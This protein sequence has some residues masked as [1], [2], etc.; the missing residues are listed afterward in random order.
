MFLKINGKLALLNNKLVVADGNGSC[1]CANCEERPCDNDNPCGAPG[2]GCQC[3]PNMGDPHPNCPQ[4]NPNG[5]GWCRHN[6][7]VD[8]GADGSCPPGCNCITFRDGGPDGEIK[9]RCQGGGWGTCNICLGEDGYYYKCGN[10]TKEAIQQFRCE[11]VKEPGGEWESR[12]CA[13]VLLCCPDIDWQNPPPNY[14]GVSGPCPPL[15]PPL[16]ECGDDGKCYYYSW[17][18]AC[19]PAPPPT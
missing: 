10:S 5:A 16:E 11:W 13:G 12:G 17:G 14:V 4:S 1:C 8:C 2:P 3:I 15:P 18:D 19:N 6:C 7:D 9:S